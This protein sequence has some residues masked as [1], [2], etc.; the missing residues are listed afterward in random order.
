MDS[1]I[2]AESVCKSAVTPERS[3]A[4]RPLAP[5]SPLGD[6]E[7]DW[8]AESGQQQRLEGAGPC[9]EAPDLSFRGSLPSWIQ[10]GSGIARV[11]GLRGQRL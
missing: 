6:A 4:R 7:R 1:L 11:R 5:S 2:I 3:R 8:L 9:W 10:L